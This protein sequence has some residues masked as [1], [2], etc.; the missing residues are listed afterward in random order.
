MRLHIKQGAAWVKNGGVI[1]YPTEAVYGLGCDPLDMAAVHRLL[2]LKQRE[3]SMGLILIADSFKRVE[4][5]LEPMV[6]SQRSRLQNSWPGP[7]TWIIPAQ[8]WVP[9]WLTGDKHTIA[10]R[11]TD[12][13]IAAA[14]CQEADMPI[15]STSANIHGRRPAQSTLQVHRQFEH[16]LDYIVPGKTGKLDKPTMIK[17]L[18]SNK[19]L[20]PA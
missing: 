2:A 8:A 18:V 11:V 10:V 1:A 15:V 5:F 17:D 7:V 12:H 20:R 9:H 4:A 16:Q 14:L 13:P 6:D 19:V 3:A